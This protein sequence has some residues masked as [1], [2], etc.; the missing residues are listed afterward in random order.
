MTD[1][2]LMTLLLSAFAVGVFGTACLW[3][4]ERSARKRR[5]HRDP[6]YA[7]A[8]TRLASTPTRTGTVDEYR[9]AAFSSS[10]DWLCSGIHTGC[11]DAGDCG[12]GGGGCD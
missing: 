8:S 2:T 9:P 12:S 3:W 10:S 11:S 1:V 6:P 4:R 7:S 5:E